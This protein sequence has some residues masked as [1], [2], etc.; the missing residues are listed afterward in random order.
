[1]PND[2]AFTSLASTHSAPEV[3][4]TLS[5][6][7]TRPEPRCSVGGGGV[8]LDFGLK[9]LA[10]DKKSLTISLDPLI[11][12]RNKC[13]KRKRVSEGCSVGLFYA[14]YTYYTRSRA[15]SHHSA[16]RPLV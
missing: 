4:S 13:N 7:S 2:C 12:L 15:A 9:F 11:S 14:Y 10:I 6:L 5:T 3:I 16:G 1:M 8:A